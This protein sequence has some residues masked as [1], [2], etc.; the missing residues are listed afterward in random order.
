MRRGAGF[1]TSNVERTHMKHSPK[2][3]RRSAVLP[4]L[5]VVGVVSAVLLQGCAAPRIPITTLLD[6]PSRFEGK[7]VR[8]VGD[9]ES[10]VGALGLGTYQVNDG[11]GTL[12]VVSESGGAPRVGANVG[13]EGTFRSAFTIGLESLA[14]LLEKRRYTP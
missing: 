1:V 12:R 3:P 5:L 13:V 6:D 14:V 11:T 9:V 2:E 10:P 7:T 8:I 4:S